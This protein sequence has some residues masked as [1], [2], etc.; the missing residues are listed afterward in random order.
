ML[1]LAGQKTND[2]SAGVTAT[3]CL[4]SAPSALS[5]LSKIS[6]AFKLNGKLMALKEIV[7]II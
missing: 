3:D 7:H 4:L 6:S 1:A 5:I 2:S